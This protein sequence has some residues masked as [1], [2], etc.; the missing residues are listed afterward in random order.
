MFRRMMGDEADNI[1]EM[2]EKDPSMMNQMVGY[3]K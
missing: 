1:E 3:W 2:L